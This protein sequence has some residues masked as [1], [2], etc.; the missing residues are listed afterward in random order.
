MGGGGG[1]EG[2]FYNSPFCHF[3]CGNE[4]KLRNVPIVHKNNSRGLNSSS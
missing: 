2:V 1:G 3:V 4:L